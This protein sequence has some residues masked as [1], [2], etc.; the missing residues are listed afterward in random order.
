MDKGTRI[1]L[2]SAGIASGFIGFAHW[3]QTNIKN[4][5]HAAVEAD[6]ERIRKRLNPPSE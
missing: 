6:K 1:L 5:M 2:V 4:V 3:S